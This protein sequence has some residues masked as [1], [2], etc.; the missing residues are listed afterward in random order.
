MG[1]ESEQVS[2]TLSECVNSCEHSERMTL[3]GD[4]NDARV[5]KQDVEVL[6][7]NFGAYRGSPQVD[8]HQ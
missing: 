6:V 1:E 4:I 5:R 7:S 8:Q 2:K 3:F